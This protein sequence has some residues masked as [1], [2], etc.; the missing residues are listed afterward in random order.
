MFLFVGVSDL[1][2][3]T[4]VNGGYY[5]LNGKGSHAGGN[6]YS[7]PSGGFPAQIYCVTCKGK[8]GYKTGKN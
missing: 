6:Y 8:Q 3:A 4:E 5:D 1:D 2:Y 7:N